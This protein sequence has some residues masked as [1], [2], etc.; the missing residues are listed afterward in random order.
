MHQECHQTFQNSTVRP[1]PSVQHRL[2]L[3]SLLCR[4]SSATSPLSSQASPESC[5]RLVQ[6][7]GCE[8]TQVVQVRRIRT[9]S[10]RSFGL[11]ACD[12]TASLDTIGAPIYIT[13]R[14]QL[15]LLGWLRGRII[16]IVRDRVEVAELARGARVAPPFSELLSCH[17]RPRDTFCGHRLWVPAHMEDSDTPR[18]ASF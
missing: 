11:P 12:D 5:F 3:H 10:Q 14:D 18:P 4:S 7:D 2:H 16:A 17:A 6:C 8:S 9:S 15:S 13:R 1:R